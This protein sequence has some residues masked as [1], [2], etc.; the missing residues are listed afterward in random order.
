MGLKKYQNLYKT[1]GA[2]AQKEAPVTREESMEQTQ[3][4]PRSKSN[5]NTE[6]KVLIENLKKLISGKLKDPQ[7]A[8]KAAQIITDM[9]TKK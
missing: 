2:S 8:K 3:I 4:N 9:M 6:E 7:M 1:S 5:N